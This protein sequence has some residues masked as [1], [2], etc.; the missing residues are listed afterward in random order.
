M[1]RWWKILV[2]KRFSDRQKFLRLRYVVMIASSLAGKGGFKNAKFILIRYARGHLLESLKE[3]F[4][5][6]PYPGEETL[7]KN[8]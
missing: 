4:L 2:R 7:S 3:P 6:R 5:I 8:P 1:F